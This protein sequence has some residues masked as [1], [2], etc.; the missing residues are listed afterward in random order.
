MEARA[1]NDGEVETGGKRSRARAVQYVLL[2][3]DKMYVPKFL[4]LYIILIS[5]IYFEVSIKTAINYFQAMPL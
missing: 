5:D 1:R 2:C 3:N 4:K